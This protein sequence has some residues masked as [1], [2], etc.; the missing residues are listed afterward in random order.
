M[1]FSIEKK[2]LSPE[3]LIELKEIKKEIKKVITH[4]VNS[5]IGCKLTSAN[6]EWVTDNYDD[7]EDPFL[8]SCHVKGMPLDHYDAKLQL[9]KGED[10]KVTIVGI[11]NGNSNCS[12]FKVLGE[13]LEVI[14]K[15]MD[16]MF[17]KFDMEQ[18]LIASRDDM[19]T[20]SV[21]YEYC[22]HDEH[23][24]AAA[25]MSIEIQNNT[26]DIIRVRR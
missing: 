24:E 7:G 6:F 1:E 14:N 13:G 25:R 5:C 16:T 26:L 3:A 20:D 4:L 18:M 11:Y 23:T 9:I 2:L 8:F 12:G 15:Y 10:E 21:F 22:T 17:I 19:T